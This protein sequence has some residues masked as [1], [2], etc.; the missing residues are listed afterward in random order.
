MFERVEHTTE[1][2]NRPCALIL[3]LNVYSSLSE[4]S[5]LTSFIV[6]WESK[7]TPAPVFRPQ[8]VLQARSLRQTASDDVRLQRVGRYAGSYPPGIHRGR[9]SRDFRCRQS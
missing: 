6:L 3:Y 8:K 7:N 1:R 4:R 9:A 2:R 5:L